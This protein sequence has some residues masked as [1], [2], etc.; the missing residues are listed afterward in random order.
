MDGAHYSDRYQRGITLVT[1]LIFLILISVMSATSMRSSRLNVRMSQNEEARLSAVETAQGLTEMIADSPNLTPVIGGANFTM[2]T[3]GEVGCNLTNIVLPAGYLANEIA[4]GHLSA[5]V[6]RLS[7]AEK[8]PPRLTSSSIDKFSAAS[9]QITASF[10]RAD[11]GLGRAR[12][13]EG[14]LVLVPKL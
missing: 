10:D 14:L 8:P 6:Q 5:R 11:E 3:T 9:F 2:C 4:A 7:P 13:S 12:L 1:S